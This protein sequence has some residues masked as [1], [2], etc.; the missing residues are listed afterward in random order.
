[1]ATGQQPSRDRHTSVGVSFRAIEECRP[2]GSVSG[3]GGNLVREAR[4]TPSVCLAAFAVSPAL[5]LDPHDASTRAGS[6]LAANAYV[7][8]GPSSPPRRHGGD[9]ADPGD[10]PGWLSEIRFGGTTLWQSR[11]HG[12]GGRSLCDRQGSVEFPHP[13]VR[14]VVPRHPAQ[15]PT[16]WEAGISTEGGRSQ[17]YAGVT[18]TVP[19]PS[20][21]SRGIFRRAV[22]TRPWRTSR[23]LLGLPF[24]FRES[25]GLGLELGPHWRVIG[26]IRPFLAFRHLRQ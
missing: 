23:S 10:S 25:I 4:V 12:G 20:I 22:T 5:A 1:M 11:Q 13:R 9:E 6:P 16:H 26:G 24:L 2:A 3:G 21:L 15:A 17:F 18:S 14:Q 8:P 19:L 7:A